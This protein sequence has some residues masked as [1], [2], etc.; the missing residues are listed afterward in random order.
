[1]SVDKLMDNIPNEVIQSLARTLLPAIREYF[2]SEEGQR[3]FLIWQKKRQEG[4]VAT[5][6][7]K[8]E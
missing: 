4:Q 2:D 8:H 5:K 1:M 6:S 3:E 7:A